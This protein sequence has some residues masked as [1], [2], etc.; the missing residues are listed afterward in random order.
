MT[1]KAMLVAVASGLLLSACGGTTHQKVAEIDP[2]TGTLQSKGE[3]AK[4]TVVTA[5]SGSL[6]RY[7]S[8]VF[9][10]HGNDYAVDQMKATKLFKTVLDYN[11]LQKIV[12]QNNLQEK[13][14]TINEPIGL[15]RLAKTWKPLLW[16]DFRRVTKDNRTY[17]RMLAI[18]PENLDELFIAD[19]DPFW[20]GVSD[21][22]VRYPLFN[23]FIDW[24][25]ANP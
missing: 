10:S 13:V 14:Q 22:D 18:N 21:Q 24:V 19:V 17:Y 1:S 12:I 8:T 9:V 11:D 16:V 4:A 6:A 20:K 25:R 7:N 23:A 5:K 2:K 15:S 3:V